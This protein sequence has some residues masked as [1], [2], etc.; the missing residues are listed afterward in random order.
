MTGSPGP[1]HSAQN[2]G[3]SEASS[4]AFCAAP[5]SS[6]SNSGCGLQNS[7]THLSDGWVQLVHHQSVL[8]F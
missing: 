1:I 6:C 7:S 2:H 5:T 3:N 8:E 4:F